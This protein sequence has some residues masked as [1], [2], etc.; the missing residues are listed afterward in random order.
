MD[1]FTF[2]T[3][4]Q[5]WIC[6]ICQRGV[7]PQQVRSHI[8]TNK[9]HRSSPCNK[10][11]SLPA[12]EVELAVAEAWA[13]KPWDP[14]TSPFMPPPPDSR[15]IPELP[16]YTGY[17]CTEAGCFYAA[18]KTE[19][20][21]AHR[22][23]VHGRRGRPRRPDPAH[24]A[25]SLYPPFHCQRMFLRCEFSSFFILGKMEQQHTTTICTY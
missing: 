25:R 16:V 13:I 24:L 8:T 17:G 19:T 12:E 4:H 23:R 18:R 6:K 15:P 3:T 11:R 10:K 21:R 20:M 9:R 1:H 2:N 22:R 14:T 5:V 7:M